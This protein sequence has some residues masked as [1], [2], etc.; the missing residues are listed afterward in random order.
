MAKPSP[1]R[2]VVGRLA[3]ETSAAMATWFADIVPR[4]ERG[5][6]LDALAAAR[7]HGL[8]Y[9]EGAAATIANWDVAAQLL[10]ALQAEY[11]TRVE[12]RQELKQ[13]PV[14]GEIAKLFEELRF[15]NGVGPRDFDRRK[16][17]ERLQTVR[18][19]MPP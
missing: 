5:I 16:F 4:K 14:A 17:F 18:A 12:Q 1:D 11:L 3:N 15:Q 8:V 9:G 19:M 10:V 13:T 2:D 7:D 6:N